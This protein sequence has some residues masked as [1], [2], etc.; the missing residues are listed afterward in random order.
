MSRRAKSHAERL[1]EF[2]SIDQLDKV[3]ATTALRVPVEK[4]KRQ[5]QTCRD[6]RHSGANSLLSVLS[7]GV[8]EIPLERGPEKSPN[9]PADAEVVTEQALAK[10]DVSFFST[11]IGGE[12]V[13]AVRTFRRR[14]TASA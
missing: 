3:A 8:G 10:P 5:V 9:T 12:Q 4:G 7:A 1:F 6:Q 2:V 13:E 11:I 14:A